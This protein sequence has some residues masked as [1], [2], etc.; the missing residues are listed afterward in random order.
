MAAPVL[1]QRVTLLRVP[2]SN[3]PHRRYNPLTGEWVLVSPHRTDRPWQG[4]QEAPTPESRPTYDPTCYLCPG[5]ERAGGV[6]NAKY[7]DTFVF[8]NDFGALFPDGGSPVREPGSVDLLQSEPAFG[9]CRVICY[10][11]RHDLSLADMEPGAITRVVDVWADQI[12][13]LGAKYA[14][15]QVFENKGSAMGASNPH[16]HGQVWTTSYLP[17]LPAKETEM[18]ASYELMHGRVLLLDV[19]AREL[20][21]AKRIVTENEHWVMLVPFWAVWPFEYLLLPRR[22]VQRLPDLTAAERRSLAEILKD[23]L[24][25][26]G[27]LFQ[28][29]FPYSMGWHRELLPTASTTLG[30]NYTLTSF[31]PC[32]DQ[33][34]CESSWSAS[35]CW[36]SLSGI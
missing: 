27:A 14:W 11:P 20:A 5:N 30:G 17:T 12:T 8:S 31:R 23:G 15:V 13:E 16:P 22:H 25:R 33:R 3:R 4:A 28:V 18:Q 2:P 19:L 36:P 32:F 9:E 7:D 29:S 21:E 6:K 26:Y 1:T 34:M 35:R 24:R 10:S